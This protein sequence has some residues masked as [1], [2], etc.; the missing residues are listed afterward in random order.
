MAGHRI[1]KALWLWL[2]TVVACGGGQPGGENHQP[3]GNPGGWQDTATNDQEAGMIPVEKMDSIKSTFDRKA[4]AVSRCLVEA[5]DA[6]E[7][8]K[9]DRAVITVTV[10][11]AVDGSASNVRVSSAEPKSKVFADCVVAD[12]ERIEFT[13]LPRELDYSYTFA[14]DAL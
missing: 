1:E 11:I 8:G 2:V 12:V 13:P 5:M 9:N 7:I 10:T 14:F 6:H 4:R 3:R